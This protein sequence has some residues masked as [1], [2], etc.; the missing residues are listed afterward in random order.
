MMI[1]VTI[2][3]DEIFAPYK[4]EINIKKDYSCSVTNIKKM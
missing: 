1:C 2:W 3:M 4:T